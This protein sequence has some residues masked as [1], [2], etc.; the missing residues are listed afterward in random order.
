VVNQMRNWRLF[1]FLVITLTTVTTLN[2]LSGTV[3]AAAENRGTVEVSKEELSWEERDAKILLK[4]QGDLVVQKQTPTE[5]PNAMPSPT[6][7]PQ[8]NTP[9][10]TPS[11]TVTPQGNTPTPTPSPT[12][13]P[14]GNTP[15]PTPSPTVTPQGNAPTPTPSPTVT[16]QGN[17]PTPTP[18]PTVTPQ[19][20]TPTPTP[21]PTVTPQGNTPTP[22]P[23]PTV[24]PQG[25]T[26]TPN[27]SPTVTPQGNTP[28]PT[29]SPTVTPQGNTPNPLPSPLVIPQGNTANPEPRVL[30]SEVLVTGVEGTLKDLVYQTIQT[31]PGRTATRT[32]LQQDVTAIYNT[33]FFSNIKVTPVDTPLGVK[34]VFDVQPN[35]I[36]K[37]VKLSIVPESDT[38]QAIPPDV[39]N[40]IFSSQYGKMLN[41]KDL[42]E[43]IKKVNE[44]YSK[45]GYELAQVLTSPKVSEDGVVTLVLSQG[46]IE[47]IQV[48]FFTKQEEPLKTGKTRDFI[49]TREMQLKPG[50]IFN[51]KIAQQDLQRIYGLGIFEDVKFS[52][53]PGK[54]PR[55]VIISVNVVEG[56]SGSVGAGAGY[57]S[58]AGIFGTVSYQEQNVGGNNQTLGLEFQGS[59]QQLLFN[60][61]FTDPWIATEPNRLSYTFNIFRS[62]S[63]SLVY[64]GDSSSFVTANGVSDPEIFRTGIGLTFGIPLAP[65]VFTKPEWRLAAGF[66]FQ[67]VEIQDTNGN[68]QPFS[69]S[70]NGYPP[71]A[72]TANPSG[73]D[74]L[75]VFSVSATRDLRDNPL[76]PTSG[77]SL[78]LSIDQA[79]PISSNISFTRLRA[80]YSYYIPLKLLNF[81]FSQGPQALAFNFQGGALLNSFPPYEAFVVGGSSSVRGYADGEVGSGRYYAQGT[82]EYRFPIY[83]IVGGAIFFDYGTTLGSQNEVPGSPAVARGLPG[84]GYSYGIGVRIQSPVG[85]IRI[86]YGIPEPYHNSATGAYVSGGR[87]Q[88]GIGERF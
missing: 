15:T 45:K 39:L 72:F 51:R 52:F 12:V 24:T 69:Q 32:Q 70:L 7:T 54:D 40:E 41:W 48:K 1:H 59:F 26:P 47:S 75:L 87:I 74:Y 37:E 29:P 30:V 82:V 36:L 22:N 81:D 14:Q 5:E 50:D 85:A 19:G 18:S 10:P 67:Q 35:P 86:D 61:S 25:N 56:K 20:N 88:F 80:N 63:I 8:G 6:V 16:P 49:I 23:S 13:T 21:S 76:Q 31:V 58:E 64:T 43:S 77:S 83:A 68:I 53:S 28:T 33:G 9:T 55:K 38:K 44:W 71:I 57:S 42:Q 46:L 62:S 17:T 27:P 34:I 73:I 79:A 84:S 66:V 60:A 4:R 2:F 11:P 65:N 78:R 3:K